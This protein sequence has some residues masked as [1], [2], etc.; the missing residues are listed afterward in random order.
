MTVEYLDHMGTDLDVVNAA[1]V[2]FDKESEWEVAGI[3]GIPGWGGPGHRKLK[4]KDVRLLHFLARGMTSEDL[5]A[6]MDEIAHPVVEVTADRA[7]I[8]ECFRRYRHR[9]LHWSPFAHVIVKMRVTAPFAI[10][11]Q[12]ETHQIGLAANEVSRRYVDARP[13][14]ARPHVWRSR[15]GDRKQGS[16]GAL[17]EGEAVEAAHAYGSAVMAALEA[18]DRM[19]SIGVAPEQARFVLPAGAY[20]TWIWTGSLLAFHRVCQHRLGADAQAEVRVVAEG[21][22]DV[23]AALFPASWQALEAH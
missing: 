6:L 20:T 19:I 10:A 22:R 16:G 12:L 15:P 13:A 21:I 23:C 5:E 7:Q 3:A 9:P 11:R 8:R 17:S 2:S 4:E 14:V 1:R 18:Y